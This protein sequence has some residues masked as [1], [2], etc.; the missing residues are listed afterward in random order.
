[1]SLPE[2]VDLALKQNANI[3]KGKNDVEAAYGVVLQ[4]RAVVM[5]KVR[6]TGNFTGND[7]G[8]QESFPSPFPVH[9]PNQNW[10]VDLRVIQPIYE[11]GRLRSALREAKLTQEQAV[12]QYQAVIADTIL[13]VQVAYYDALVAAQQIAVQEASLNLLTNQLSDTRNRFEAGTVR[14]FNVLRAEVELANARPRL[15]RARNASRFSQAFPRKQAVIKHLS[16]LA[17]RDVAH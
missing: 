16:E 1:L 14:P 5:P 17:R 7:P 15:I 6:S 13:D 8:L 10:F 12:A 11:G 2:A 9:L 3:L 4:N